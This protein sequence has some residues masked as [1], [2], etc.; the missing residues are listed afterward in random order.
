[1][2]HGTPN[3]IGDQ[4]RTGMTAC[5]VVVR[6]DTLSMS[7]RGTITGD[8]AVRC[9]DRWFPEERW[10]EIPVALLAA[11]L[12]QIQ[13]WSR[14]EVVERRCHFMDGPFELVLK[15]RA[16]NDWGVEARRSGGRVFAVAV[17]PRKLWES[18]IVAGREVLAVARTERWRSRDL[19]ELDHALSEA[20]GSHT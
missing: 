11:W 7:S 6:L 10:N 3:R 18:A 4:Q 20:S 8:V 13:L 15:H 5:E 19:D 1:M 16:P 12:P 14:G 17:D 2:R 9:A